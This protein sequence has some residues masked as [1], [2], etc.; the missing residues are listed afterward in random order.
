MRWDHM[1]GLGLLPPSTAD[2][3][4]KAVLGV[5]V[6]L[7]ALV[8]SRKQTLSAFFGSRVTVGH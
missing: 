7:P 5:P 1:E 2:T 4:R 6:S 8:V 3:L